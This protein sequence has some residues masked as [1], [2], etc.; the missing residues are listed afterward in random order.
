MTLVLTDMT[1]LSPT[2][3][4]TVKFCLGQKRQIKKEGNSSSVAFLTY[5]PREIINILIPQIIFL[6]DEYAIENAM[7][8]TAQ[9]VKIIAHFNIF[10]EINIHMLRSTTLC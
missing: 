2:C 5:S 9:L 7:R 10:G 8:N 1:T 6:L 4:K 3:S